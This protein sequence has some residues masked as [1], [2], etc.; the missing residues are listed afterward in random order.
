MKSLDRKIKVFYVMTFCFS[1]QKHIFTTSW[2]TNVTSRC[3]KIQQDAVNEACYKKCPGRK[4]PDIT[5]S[6]IPRSPNEIHPHK[7]T[8]SPLI[9]S[10]GPDEFPESS[11][12]HDIFLSLKWVS[13]QVR[14]CSDLAL[15][16]IN[17]VSQHSHFMQVSNPCDHTSDCRFYCSET[18]CRQHSA[19]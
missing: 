6:A 3:L 5:P 4:Q 14:P 16:S 19:I 13:K 7:N 8:V 15:T 12:K 10:P 2:Y 1:L 11:S 9:S 18:L 17:T